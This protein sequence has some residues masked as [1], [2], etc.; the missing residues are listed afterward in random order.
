MIVDL[1]AF[2]ASGTNDYPWL[3]LSQGVGDSRPVDPPPLARK[4]K[5]KLRDFITRAEFP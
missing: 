5:A 2:T 1:E 4:V 3:K